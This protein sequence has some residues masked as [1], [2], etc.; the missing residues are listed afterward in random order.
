MKY[1]EIADISESADAAARAKQR[2]KIVQRL[3]QMNRRRIELIARQVQREL[4][5][6]FSAPEMERFDLEHQLD[7]L[8]C[9]PPSGRK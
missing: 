3:E 1:S 2:D 7:R 8:G 6:Y 4:R 5:R 9:T